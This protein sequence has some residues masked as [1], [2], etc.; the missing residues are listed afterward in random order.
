MT[1]LQINPG[2]WWRRFVEM[3][4]SACVIALLATAAAVVVSLPYDDIARQLSCLRSF[5]GGYGCAS[6]SLNQPV[7]QPNLGANPS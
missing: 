7:Q 6:L 1:R 4:E 5:G 2:A 3:F